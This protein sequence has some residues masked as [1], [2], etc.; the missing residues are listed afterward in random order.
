MKTVIVRLFDP[1]TGTGEVELS[2]FVED[3]AAG[4]RQRFSGQ[5]ELMEAIGRIADRPGAV[6][7]I[8]G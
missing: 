6:E 7:E 1:A 5:Q 8:P 2:G 4:T 3:V